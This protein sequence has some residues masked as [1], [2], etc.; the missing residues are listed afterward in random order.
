[1]KIK[2]YNIYFVDEGILRVGEEEIP[3]IYNLEH[4]AKVEIYKAL[5]KLLMAVGGKEAELFIDGK[6]YLKITDFENL[7]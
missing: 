3:G 1:M 7:K 5:V 4:D 6:E 2:N